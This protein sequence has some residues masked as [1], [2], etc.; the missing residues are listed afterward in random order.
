MAAATVALSGAYRDRVSGP[1][2]AR[3]LPYPWERGITMDTFFVRSQLYVAGA[4]LGIFELT[5]VLVRI[6]AR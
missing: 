3:R 6:F 4:L 1:V 5:F 2:A